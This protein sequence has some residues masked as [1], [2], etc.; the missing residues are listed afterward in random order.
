MSSLAQVNYR[1]LGESSCLTSPIQA[2][3]QYQT[4]QQLEKCL[5]R[6]TQKPIRY[7]S[8]SRKFSV[9]RGGWTGRGSAF[10]IPPKN[11]IH[12]LKTH[13]FRKFTGKNVFE[14]MDFFPLNFRVTNKTE[15]CKILTS[16]Y[17]P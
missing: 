16:R 13:N 1:R 7:F 2:S 4:R 6:I 11:I 10:L 5:V 12:Y 3:Y 8:N 14:R 15:V 9:R 17:S